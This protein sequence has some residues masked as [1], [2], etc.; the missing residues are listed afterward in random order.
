MSPGEFYFAG[1]TVG[2]I[3]GLTIR[4]VGMISSG[5][6]TLVVLPL[7]VVTYKYYN[8]TFLPD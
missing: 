5:L 1:I 3:V 6:M 4:S 7:L 8:T 2:L